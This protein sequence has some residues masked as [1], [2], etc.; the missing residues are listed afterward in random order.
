MGSR[1]EAC[2]AEA[3]QLR[4]TLA[5]HFVVGSSLLK[6]KLGTMAFVRAAM[7][8]NQIQKLTAVP[9]YHRGAG[10]R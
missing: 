10:P 8:V 5:S 4:G 2:I 6:W 1:A 3:E 9:P 7:V